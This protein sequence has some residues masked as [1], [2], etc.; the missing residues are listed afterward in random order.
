[1]GTDVERVLSQ[2]DQF[3]DY[4]ASDINTLANATSYQ[5]TTTG[6]HGETEI[7]VSFDA[8]TLIEPIRILFRTFTPGDYSKMCTLRD[9]LYTSSN[10]FNNGYGSPW[11][12]LTNLYNAINE[13]IK[14]VSSNHSVPYMGNKVALLSLLQ[15]LLSRANDS[16][17]ALIYY[18]DY[19]QRGYDHIFNNNL[20]SVTF[21]TTLSRSS[22]GNLKQTYDENVNM[23]TDSN[24]PY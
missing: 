8:Y 5:I 4:A 22:I 3:K 21:R 18:H 12:E 20:P 6:V 10:S 23:P 24:D 2:I 13:V 1:M 11:T 7:P 15:V 19:I 17:H 14:F 16:R 9:T